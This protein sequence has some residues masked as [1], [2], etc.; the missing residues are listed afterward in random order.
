MRVRSEAIKLTIF[1][2]LGASVA[3]LLYLTLGRVTIGPTNEYSAMMS[4][5]SGLESGDVIRV[6]GVRVGQVD[7][8]SV[9]SGNQVEVKFH[10]DEGQTLTDHTQVLV[11]YENLLGDRYLELAQQ[12]G[13]GAPLP[14]GAEIPLARTTPA[15][16]L[17]VLLN[18]FKPL[19]QGLEP[20]EVNKLATNLIATLQGQGGTVQ[21][22][23]AQTASFTNGLANDDQVIGSLISNLDVVLGSLDS[24][25]QQLR[26][27]IGQFRGLISGLADDREPIGES[28]TSINRLA[29]TLDELYREVR[30]PLTETVDSTRATTRILNENS[31]SLASILKSLPPAYQLL[32]RVG[33]HGNFFN[34]FLCSVQVLVSN[35]TGGVIK[36]PVVNSTVERCN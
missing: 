27:T 31:K 26:Q 13:E 5:V 21:S 24:R 28:V 4:D 11:R 3:G 8:L 10:V 19:F 20:Q 12:P 36:S 32:D 18:G 15:L 33:S 30:E 9:R 17:D 7:G 23:L 1:V 34:F 22:L 35:P 29:A 6:A 2:T 25:D 16:D 14:E